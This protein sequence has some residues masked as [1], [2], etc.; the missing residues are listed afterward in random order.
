MTTIVVL[1]N[2][3]PGVN[4]TDYQQWARETDLP[5]AGGLPSVDSF[6]IL[7][8]QGLLMSEDKPPYDYI[9][10]LKINDMDQFGK[11][12]S[13]ETMQKVAG[14]FQSFA[15]NPLFIMTSKL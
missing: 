7:Q 15:D 12:V 11:D 9:E 5:T 10:I 4:E 3:K 2:L 6:E 13:S 8:S 1:F 14:E